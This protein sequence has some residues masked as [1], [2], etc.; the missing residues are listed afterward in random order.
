MVKIPCVK[1]L[2]NNLRFLNEIDDIISIDFRRSWQGVGDFSLVICGMHTGIKEGN[3]IMLGNNGHRCGI[4]RKTVP[5]ASEKG[6][7]ITVTGQTLNGLTNQRTV[8][9]YESSADGG[10]FAVP[11]PTESRK[12]AS[13]EEIIKTFAEACMGDDAGEKRRF[14]N[15]I[16]AECKKRGIQTNWISRYGQLNKELEAICEY[17]DCGYEIYA[18]LQS[19]KLVFD[20]LPGVD[21]SVSQSENSRVIL[22]RDFESVKN[23]QYSRDFSNYKNLAYCAGVGEG[24]DRTVIAVIPKEMSDAPTGFDRHEVFIDCGTLEAV[25]TNTSISL[26]EEGQHRLEEYAAIITLNADILPDGSFTYGKQ[27][28]LGDMVT[29]IENRFDTMQDMRVIEI[30]ESYEPDVVVVNATLGRLPKKL[31]RTLRSLKT[32]VK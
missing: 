23:I 20:Y 16:F 21:R 29:V 25:E 22:S 1:I 19:K 18:D 10:Y 26:Q 5:V 24:A 30:C 27:W 3:I 32:P 8:L 6:T 9:P 31:G 14:E 4:I 13:A 11:R 17:C 12:Y 2:D 28:D 15:L 7:I